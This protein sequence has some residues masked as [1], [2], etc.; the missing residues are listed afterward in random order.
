MF[1]I[2]GVNRPL[3]SAA[4]GFGRCPSGAQRYDLVISLEV[5]EHLDAKHLDRVVEARALPHTRARAHTRTHAHTHAHKSAR[6]CSHTHTHTLRH[7][8][9]HARRRTRTRP[10]L[11]SS[12]TAPQHST[13]QHSTAQHSTAPS[14]SVRKPLT[15]PACQAKPSRLA[16]AIA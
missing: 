9:T 7:S 11:R 6:T 8:G 3:A 13:A 16:P 10:C 1:S 5:L 2:G 12:S 14:T 4:V 15:L